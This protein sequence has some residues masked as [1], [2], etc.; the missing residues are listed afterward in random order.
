M[1]SRMSHRRWKVQC[2]RSSRNLRW[3][4]SQVACSGAFMVA[5]VVLAVMPCS[6]LPCAALPTALPAHLCLDAPDASRRPLHRALPVLSCHRPWRDARGPV[7]SYA[8]HNRR[9]TMEGEYLRAHDTALDRRPD[10]HHSRG[11]ARAEHLELLA[12]TTSSRSRCPPRRLPLIR[13]R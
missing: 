1:C 3:Q 11:G 9:L 5:P 10:G 8:P 6:V 2:L 7:A 4:M 13:S 12:D